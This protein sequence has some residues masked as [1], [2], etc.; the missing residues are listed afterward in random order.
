MKILFISNFFPPTH[1]AGTENYTYGIAHAL[2]QAG[3]AVRV[4][5]AGQWDEG[6][7]HWNGY[8]EDMYNDVPIRRL[9]LNWTKAPDPNRYLY[10]NPV[11][12]QHLRDYLKRFRPHIVHITS[13][14]TLSASAIHVVKEANIPLVITLT[15]F[16]FL[17]PRLN[18]LRSDGELCDGRTTDQE[19]LR[20]ML[21]N[22]K[23]YSFPSKVLPQPVVTRFLSMLSRYPSLTRWRGLRG[24][25]INITHRKAFL[26]ST[27]ALAD[28]VIAPSSFLKDIFHLNGFS[29]PIQVLPYGH[30]LS[31][32]QGYP[33]KTPSGKIR[34]GYIGQISFI[35]GVHVLV[36]A[37]REAVSGEEA[38]L[39]IFGAL[40]KSPA[41]S[42]Q[43]QEMAA[44]H[45]GIQFMG[46]FDHDRLG[47]VLS[48]ID[49]LVVPSLWYENNPLVIQEAFAT[50]TPVI[51]TNLG[52]MSEFV[53]HEVNGLLFER[54]SVP[55]LA[56]QIR[57]ILQTP[58]LLDRLREGIPPV[59]R[60]E[61]E[62]RE[63][64]AIYEQLIT[65]RVPVGEIAYEQP[66]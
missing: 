45:P 39:S 42:L 17:C 13:C 65:P 61:E 51:A 41:Y 60:I 12:A 4:L 10:D 47:E 30:D 22:A 16:W 56:R 66:R 55:D 14:Y 53:R 29:F 32:L 59:R 50:Q 24:M 34:F 49:V 8:S 52:G 63:L 40:G 5:C 48:Q 2:L 15:D 36:Q 23:V 44:H 64:T 11:V 35:K 9:H 57:R 38:S 20:C 21:R 62:V 43:L 18:L 6:P 25:G 31:W 26:R 58:A 54:A 33:G 28:H 46:A 37:F 27:L 1:T 7:Q 19:C 3:H